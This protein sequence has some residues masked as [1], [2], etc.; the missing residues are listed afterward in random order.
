[1][2]GLSDTDELIG[3]ESMTPLEREAVSKLVKHDSHSV[4]LFVDTRTTLLR[5]VNSGDKESFEE[6]YNIYCPAMLKYLGLSEGSRAERDQWDIVQTVFAKFYK[7]FALVEDPSSGARVIPRNLMEVLVKTDK[8]TGRTANVKFRQYLMTCLK[9]AVRSQWRHETKK[10]K[11]S[12]CSIDTRISANEK[13]T[14]KDALEAQGVNPKFLDLVDEEGERLSAAWGIWQAV[15]KGFL[16]DESID[17]WKRDVI[18]QI[19][20]NGASIE[21]LAEKWGIRKNTIEVAR[22]RGRQKAEKITK[23]IYDMLSDGDA[24][25]EKESRKLYE[26]VSRMRPSRR[27]DRFMIELSKELLKG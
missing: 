16:F 2:I 19:L 26:M 5:R 17:E 7:T 12:I 15:I 22:T 1:M 11:I 4:D 18:Y 20:A 21:D 3:V 6:F 24:D 8:K 13:T 23:Q 14:W 25:L 9:N 10:G 27:I